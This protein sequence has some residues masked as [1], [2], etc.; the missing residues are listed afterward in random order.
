LFFIWAKPFLFLTILSFSF[1]ILQTKMVGLYALHGS[2][3]QSLSR[4]LRYKNKTFK[5]LK[6]SV[7]KIK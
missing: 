7:L 2:L 6:I 3:L 4:T 1:G 5:Y